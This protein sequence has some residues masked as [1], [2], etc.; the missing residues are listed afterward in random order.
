MPTWKKNIFVRV[1]SRRMAE[2]NRSAEDIAADYPALS[3]AEIAETL[4]VIVA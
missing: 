3:E 4:A 2:E 1:I